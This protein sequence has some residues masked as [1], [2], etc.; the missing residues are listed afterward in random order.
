M[1]IK[2]S[3]KK[4]MNKKRKEAVKDGGKIGK[5]SEEREKED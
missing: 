2:L 3:F 1:T 5:G 4:K